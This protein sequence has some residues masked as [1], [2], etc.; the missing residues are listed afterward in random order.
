MKKLRTPPSGARSHAPRGTHVPPL[1]F[2][3]WDIL[4][5]CLT[6]ISKLAVTVFVSLYFH[7]FWPKC[8]N[9]FRSFQKHFDPWPKKTQTLI[10]ETLFHETDS[11]LRIIVDLWLSVAGKVRGRLEKRD[12]PLQVGDEEVQGRPPRLL[13]IEAGGAAY[14]PRYFAKRHPRVWANVVT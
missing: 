12:L 2:F 5:I 3:H 1:C 4:V 7:R 8:H 6:I 13:R 11:F 10:S 9:F 14:S